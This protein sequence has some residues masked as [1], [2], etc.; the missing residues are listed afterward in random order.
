MQDKPV[1]LTR[2]G[3]AKLEAELRYLREVRRREVAERLRAAK[4]FSDAED[5]AE[6]EAARDEQAFIEGR[7]LTLQTLLAN[8]RLIDDHQ[9]SHDIVRLGSRV[10]VQDDDGETEEFIIVGSAEANPRAGKISNE[11][12]VG[13]A[14]LGHRLGETVEVLTPAGVRRLTITAIN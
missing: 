2:E 10:Q 11:S 5:N 6:Y 4:E 3:L 13:R 8:V 9:Q 12:P 1:Y 7:I 14:L